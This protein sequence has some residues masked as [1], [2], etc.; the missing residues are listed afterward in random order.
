MSLLDL[1]AL[2]ETTGPLI[3]QS[4][5]TIDALATYCERDPVAWKLALWAGTFHAGRMV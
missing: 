3:L 2:T 1:L 4:V 5:F